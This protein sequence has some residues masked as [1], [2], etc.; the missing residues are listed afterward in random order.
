MKSLIRT[1]S[2]FVLNPLES[3]EDPYAYKPSHRTI[4]IVLGV[5]FSILSSVAFFLN[6]SGDVGYL[7]PVIVFGL[8]GLVAIVVGA[9]GSDRAVAKIWGSR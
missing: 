2:S 6:D 7:F 5:L 9:V 3:G 8:V 4:L 1:L